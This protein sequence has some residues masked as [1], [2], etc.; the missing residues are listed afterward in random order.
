MKPE[1]RSL[2]S[3]GVAR[4]RPAGRG[5]TRARGVVLIYDAEATLTKH[6]TSSKLLTTYTHVIARKDGMSSRASNYTLYK[7]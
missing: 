5:Q 1:Q 2:R 6:D 7:S 4:G 3:G